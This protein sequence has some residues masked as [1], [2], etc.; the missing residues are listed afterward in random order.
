MTQFLSDKVINGAFQGFWQLEA[1]LDL[2]DEIE[3][4]QPRH[5]PFVMFPT[6]QAV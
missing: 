2:S 6:S 3:A 5:S 4:M 1:V